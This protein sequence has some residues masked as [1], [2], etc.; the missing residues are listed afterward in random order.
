MTS[1]LCTSL[2]HVASACLVNGQ[3]HRNCTINWEVKILIYEKNHAICLLHTFY[4]AFTEAVKGKIKVISVAWIEAEAFLF[5][6]CDYFIAF[7][8]E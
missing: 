4:F 2:V 3:Y 6:Y 1:K 5:Q 8:K 7:L